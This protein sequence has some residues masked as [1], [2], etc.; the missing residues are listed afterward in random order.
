MEMRIL[1]GY[2]P[3]GCKDSDMPEQLTLSLSFEEQIG[4]REE[5][6]GDRY[7]I[8][9][10]Q[11]QENTVN[12][13][14]TSNSLILQ[15]KQRDIETYKRFICGLLDIL[16]RRQWHPLQYSCLENPMDGEACWAAVHGVA[17]SRMRLSDFTF[18]FHFRAL[19]KEMATYSSVLA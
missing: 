4:M 6:T 7:N 16:G 19:E 13:K 18:T 11:Y 10:A 14:E 15:E 8:T 5:V 17:K 2:C 1:A 12:M 9:R 3:W